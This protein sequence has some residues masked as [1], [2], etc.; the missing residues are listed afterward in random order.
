MDVS[1]SIAESNEI[2]NAFSMASFWVCIRHASS[3]P[4]LDS[5]T[6]VAFSQ[7]SKISCVC[8]PSPSHCWTSNNRS[9][10][11]E[12]GGSL[13]FMVSWFLKLVNPGWWQ[14]QYLTADYIQAF[15]P[16][17]RTSEFCAC[18]TVRIASALV[19]FWVFWEEL[20]GAVFARFFAGSCSSLTSLFIAMGLPRRIYRRRGHPNSEI[21]DPG[22]NSRK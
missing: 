4:P 6:E 21:P 1:D 19:N 22:I 18:K 8:W 15:I 7:I 5:R 14:Y 9:S 2:I 3:M 10:C 20:I 11:E 17:V 13:C 12:M 16:W